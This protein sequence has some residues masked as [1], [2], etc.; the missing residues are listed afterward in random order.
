MKGVWWLS[1]LQGFYVALKLFLIATVI[2]SSCTKLGKFE[3][4]YLRN[5]GP[6][7]TT[8]WQPRYSCGGWVPGPSLNIKIRDGQVACVQCSSICI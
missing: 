2:H 6:L 7:S 3:K 4:L 5:T 1:I 8:T